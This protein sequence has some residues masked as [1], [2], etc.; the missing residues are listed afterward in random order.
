MKADL[1]KRAEGQDGSGRRV[2]S[3]RTM[4]SP[5]V[6]PAL[7]ALSTHAHTAQCGTRNKGPDKSA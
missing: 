5:D 4:W 3:E 1:K 6:A 2:A 7:A